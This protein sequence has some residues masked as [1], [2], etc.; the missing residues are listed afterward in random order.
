MN[1][2]EREELRYQRRKSERMEKLQER[3]DYLG[4]FEE[5][6]SFSNLYKSYKKCCLGVGWKA[7]TQYYKSQALLNVNKAYNDVRKPG[8]KGKGFICFEAT[9][10]GKHRHIKS[11]HISERVIQRCFCDYCLVPLFKRHFIYDNSASLKGRGITFAIDRAKT[12]LIQYYREYGKE[13]YVLQFDISKF[14]ESI[15]HE[16]LISQI[17]PKLID[18]RLFALLY[19]LI[20]MFGDKGLGLGSQISQICALLFLNELDHLVK[21]KLGIKFYGRYQDDG[22]LFHPDKEYLKKALV[23]ITSLC[24][25][26]GIKLNT[27]KTQI[28]HIKKGFTFLKIKFSLTDSGEVVMRPPSKS[29]TSVRRK[30]KKFRGW[31]DTGKFTLKNVYESFQSWRAYISRHSMCNRSIEN[32]SKL[33]KELYGI[34]PDEVPLVE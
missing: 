8:Y 9:L 25:K 7:S 5:V 12:H 29:I 33:Y 21:D 17:V 23:E 34:D 18:P 26:M 11:V 1:S 3:T 15:N 22:Y 30:L 4:S 32:V 28:I 20:K 27:K 10:R 19:R 2:L 16:Y 13:G 14:F 6:F 24:D 31:V